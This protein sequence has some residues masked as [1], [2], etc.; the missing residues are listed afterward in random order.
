MKKIYF[1]STCS[2]CNKI[3]KNLNLR[4]KFELQ[5]IKTN[6]IT[7]EQLEYLLKLGANTE[8]LFNKR[9]RK[10]AGLGKKVEEMDE[11]EIKKHILD[12]YTFL[13]RP[14]VVFNDEL[15]ISSTKDVLEKL[16]EKIKSEP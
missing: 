3:I 13:K 9:S 15:F 2:T 4:E 7:Y 16:A 1:L 8:M 6:K 10:Y 11:E 12:E 14:V 5:D